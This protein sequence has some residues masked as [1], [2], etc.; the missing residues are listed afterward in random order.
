MGGCTVFWSASHWCMFQPQDE[1]EVGE[2]GFKQ[3]DGKPGSYPGVGVCVF[4]CLARR[5]LVLTFARFPPQSS[6]LWTWTPWWAPSTPGSRTQSSSNDPTAST[7]RWIRRSFHAV[8][9]KTKAF[10]S[11]SWRGFCSTPTGE[12]CIHASVG[13]YAQL[14]YRQPVRSPILGMGHDFRIFN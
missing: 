3:Y 2:D 4:A 14:S 11:W 10:T 1:I 7:T 8:R 6:A 9:M 13:R 5:V 12:R